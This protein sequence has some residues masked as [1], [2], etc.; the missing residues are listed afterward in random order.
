[1]LGKIKH[2]RLTILSPQQKATSYKIN[3][4]TGA[5]E[6]QSV[7]QEV[8]GEAVTYYQSAS[9][10]QKNRLNKWEKK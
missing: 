3:R 7:D 8:L 9:F 2:D 6:R 1:M 5:I 4:F 10:V